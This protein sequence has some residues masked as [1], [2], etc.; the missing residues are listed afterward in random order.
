MGR[1][2]VRVSPVTAANWRAVSELTVTEEQ[3]EHVA[4]VP[5]YL[6]LCA[7][8]GDWHPEALE[9]SGCVVGF[10]MWATDTDGSR[11][12]GGLMVDRSAQRRGVARAALTQLIDRARHEGCPNVALSY[13]P[14]NTVAGRLYASMGFVPTT[15]RM[16]EGTEIVARLP[17]VVE[18]D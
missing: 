17:L 7:C 14:N 2:S 12:I 13:A 5:H 8:G 18:A 15:E 9:Q 1:E 10:V 11:W 16:D 6:N 4:P 3:A